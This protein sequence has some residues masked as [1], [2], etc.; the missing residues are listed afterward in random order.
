MKRDEIAA[1][2]AWLLQQHWDGKLRVLDMKQM[3]VEMKDH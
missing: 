1:R 3:F 2:Q